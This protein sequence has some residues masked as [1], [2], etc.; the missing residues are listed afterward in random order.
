MKI[1]L[2][3]YF[4]AVSVNNVVTLSMRRPWIQYVGSSILSVSVIASLISVGIRSKSTLI[5]VGYEII[6]FN[7]CGGILA[8]SYETSIPAVM[9]L[10]GLI[11]GCFCER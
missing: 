9:C 5:Q 6:A 10:V 11:A 8:W 1:V 3:I 7:V 2:A 4:I